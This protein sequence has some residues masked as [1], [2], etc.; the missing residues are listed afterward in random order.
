[1]VYNLHKPVG[2]RVV[3]VL[4]RCLECSVPNFSPVEDSKHYSIYVSSFLI[5]GG[6]G[7]SFD[8][9]N[10]IKISKSLFKLSENFKQTI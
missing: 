1:M 9:S 7:Y 4:A 8:R 3:S 6:D 5:N 2:N 10:H